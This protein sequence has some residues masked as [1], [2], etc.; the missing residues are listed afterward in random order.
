[1]NSLISF[2]I[3]FSGSLVFALGPPSVSANQDGVTHYKSEDYSGA[4][5]DFAKALGKDAYNPTFHFNLGDAFLKNGDAAKAMSEYEAVEQNPKASG[6]LKF[7]SMF[8]AGNAALQAKDTAKALKYYQRALDY[9][10][11][12][13][14]VKTNIELA[15][16][17]QK[18]GGS[19][20]EKKDD[21]DKKDQKDDKQQQ[22]QPNDSKQGQQE[23]PKEKPKPFQS[24]ALNENDV[25]RILEE[26]KR[27]EEQIRAK[28]N[29]DNKK[30][31]EQQVEKDW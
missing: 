2:L 21:K 1:M 11:Q 5:N 12:S 22:P 4:F 29:I 14:E 17:E 25:R 8:N 30:T 15:L 31:P 13:Q 28:Q 16:Q 19:S 24:Q 27:Q 3:I 6:E 23:K 18:G 9:N 26:L 10:P 7:K 20:D